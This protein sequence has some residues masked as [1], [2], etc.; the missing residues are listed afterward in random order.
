MENLRSEVGRGGLVAP[1]GVERYR[2]GGEHLEELEELLVGGVVG[3][4]V[5]HMGAAERSR[6]A[7]E[8]E[9]TAARDGHIL[10]A[11]L[12]LHAAAVALV[13]E[14]CDGHAELEHTRN[15]RILG[16]PR[17]DRH[18]GDAVGRARDG[19]CLRGSLSEIG[20]VGVTVGEA[21]SGRLGHD[22]DDAGAGN[23]SEGVGFVGVAGCHGLLGGREREGSDCVMRADASNT[24][25]PR[26]E[27][28]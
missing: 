16:G 22:V 9:A 12:A 2:D 11:V 14:L 3:D 13:V 26:T 10:R 6:E 20:P 15:R 27:S 21:E 25:L 5:P 8:A 4:E 28:R 19:A 17:V 24:N 23:G 1:L 7:G 18:I